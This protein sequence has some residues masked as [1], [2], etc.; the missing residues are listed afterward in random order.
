MC[1]GQPAKTRFCCTACIRTDRPGRIFDIP[2]KMLAE[3]FQSQRISIKMQTV[4]EMVERNIQPRFDI[5]LLDVLT[6][7]Q[8]M[9]DGR[10]DPGPAIGA[11]SDH[12]RV[13]ARLRQ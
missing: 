12:D 5:R 10:S 3:Y 11:A 7:L 8:S 4:P 13:R 6:G 1:L 2:A 9:I